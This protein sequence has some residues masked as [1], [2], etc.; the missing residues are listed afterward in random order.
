MII[1]KKAEVRIPVEA[2]ATIA[3]AALKAGNIYENNT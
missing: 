3:A 2:V 1:K